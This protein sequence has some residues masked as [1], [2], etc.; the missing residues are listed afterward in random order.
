MHRVNLNQEQFN[1]QVINH[2]SFGIALLSPNGLILTVNPAF[3]QTF[4]YSTEE[5][6]GMRLEDL[7]HPED[8]GNLHDL[9]AVLGEETE[10]QMEKQFITKMEII[11]GDSSRSTYSATSRTSQHTSFAKSLTLQSK[12]NPSNA[13][14]SLLNGIRRLKNIT[15]TPSFLL[16][17]MVESLIPIV[18]RK[19]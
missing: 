10:V 15:M 1:Q 6:E 17:L 16:T 2:A 8:F 19:R 11:F 12:R 13:F 18:W 7:S 3:E 9:K 4:G 5:F 14:R